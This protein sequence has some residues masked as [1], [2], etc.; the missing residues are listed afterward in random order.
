MSTLTPDPSPFQGEGSHFLSPEER[1]KLEQSS[2]EKG[3]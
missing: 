3:K 1:K 2:R